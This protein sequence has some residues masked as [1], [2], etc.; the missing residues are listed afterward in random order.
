M[1]NQHSR[2]I[3]GIDPGLVHTGWG[4]I[5][6]DGQ[7]LQFIACGVVAPDTDTTLSIRLFQLYQQMVQII[8]TY[9]PDDAAIEEIFVNHNSAS[10]LKLSMARGVLLMLPNLFDI[11]VSEYQNRV[12]KQ[13]IA[14]SGRADKQQITQMVSYLLPKAK[15]FI[16]Q[17][18]MADA[19]AIAITHAHHGKVM[20][21]WQAA[22]MKTSNEKKAKEI[23]GIAQ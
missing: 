17:H 12:V 6:T 11:K 5:D 2:R 19:L 13:A 20:E 21:K 14:G 4:V 9:Q 3:I 16:T 23:K 10:S 22:E 7:K 18:D 8:E 15:G 1:A